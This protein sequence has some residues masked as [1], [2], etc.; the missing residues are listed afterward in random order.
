[1]ERSVSCHGI[2]KFL[3]NDNGRNFIGP[4]VKEYIR[5]LNT[6]WN[7]ILECSPWWAGFW[8]RLF[9]LVKKSLREILKKN[10]LTFE[11]MSTVCKEIEGASNTRP[12][13]YIYDDSTDTIIA[14][15]HLIYRRNLLTKIPRDNDLNSNSYGKRFKYLQ[16][17][18]NRFWK[19]WTLSYRTS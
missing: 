9:Q 15:S 10:K 19:S 5:F 13:C 4:E 1:M 2:P 11:E 6:E 12:L 14:P 8:E 7:Y 17:L 3:I 16:T 18:I